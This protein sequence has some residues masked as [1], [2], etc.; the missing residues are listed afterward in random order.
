MLGKNTFSH[1]DGFV[2]HDVKLSSCLDL[3]YVLLI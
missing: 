3:I 1:C 2:V